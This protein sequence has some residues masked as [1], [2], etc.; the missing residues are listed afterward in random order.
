[1][2]LTTKLR[3]DQNSDAIF[4]VNDPETS[5]LIVCYISVSDCKVGGTSKLSFGGRGPFVSEETNLKTKQYSILTFF[6]YYLYSEKNAV[7]IEVWK[8][9]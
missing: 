6:L 8:P 9:V 3:S 2:R 1:M 7:S 4:G 5:I